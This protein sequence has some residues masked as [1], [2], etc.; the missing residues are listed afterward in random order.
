M[1]AYGTKTQ[2]LAARQTTERQIGSVNERGVVTSAEE[3]P[4]AT[5]KTSMLPWFPG[6]I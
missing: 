4:F 5:T 2:E 3:L 6:L 1:I